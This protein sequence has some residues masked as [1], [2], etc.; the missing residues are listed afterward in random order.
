MEYTDTEGRQRRQ[1]DSMEKAS[2]PARAKAFIMEC[3]MIDRVRTFA[4][5]C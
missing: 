2:E 4:T 3:A 5:G 1:R